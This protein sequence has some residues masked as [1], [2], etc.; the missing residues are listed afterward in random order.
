MGLG[1]LCTG[2]DY[3]Q[4]L[5]PTPDHLFPPPSQPVYTKYIAMIMYMSIEST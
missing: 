4:P 3:N 5:R 2:T 1:R